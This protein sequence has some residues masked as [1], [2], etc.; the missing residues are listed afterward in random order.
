MRHPFTPVILVIIIKK[1][2]NNKYWR[3]CGEQGTI[4][5]YW[6]EYKLLQP[7]WK[8]VWSF[9]KKLKLELPYDP[10]IP[11]M[12]IYLE[13]MLIQKDTCTPM[14]IAAIFTIAKTRN[15]PKCPSAEKWI[16]KMWC[17]HTHTHTHTYICL[18][19]QSEILLCSGIN[20][21][22]TMPFV[23]TWMDLMEIMSEANQRKKDMISLICGT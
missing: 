6:W 8:T 19:T 13:K 15:Q 5:H 4:L 22:E 10:A 14:F 3:G 1:S 9:L 21:N 12:G 17:I 16:K 20:K 7:L 18:Y 2:I 23:A 11:L